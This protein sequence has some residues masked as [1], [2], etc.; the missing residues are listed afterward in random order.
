ML[1]QLLQSLGVSVSSGLIVEGIKQLLLRNP[2]AT[3]FDIKTEITNITNIEDEDKLEKIYNILQGNQNII[4]GRNSSAEGSG[5]IIIGNNRNINGSDNI[6][7][8]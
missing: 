5:N 7:I 1:D 6:F 3:K 8:G 4:I 2:N